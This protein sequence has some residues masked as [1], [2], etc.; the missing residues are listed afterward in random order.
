MHPNRLGKISLL[1]LTLFTSSC[2]SKKQFKEVGGFFFSTANSIE[3]TIEY[4]FTSENSFTLKIFA[5]YNKTIKSPL[6]FYIN[7]NDSFDHLELGD[8]TLYKD[9][10]GD[11]FGPLEFNNYLEIV[12]NLSDY[13]K[14]IFQNKCYA[15]V[16]YS[17]FPFPNGR[18]FLSIEI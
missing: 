14:S 8:I 15:N 17:M 18:Y 7:Y 12:I 9:Y 13:G 6:V 11:F 16:G 4:A 2:T 1:L 5:Y 10:Y 3:F